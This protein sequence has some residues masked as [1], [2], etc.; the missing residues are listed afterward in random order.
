MG[1]RTVRLVTHLDVSHADAERAVVRLRYRPEVVT[2]SVSDDGRGLAYSTGQPPV[3]HG[4]AGMRERVA[5]YGGRLMIGDQAEGG[6]RVRA[7]FPLAA[8]S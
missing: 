6:F 8:T 2:I 5:A 7:T 3:G 4:L 1:P